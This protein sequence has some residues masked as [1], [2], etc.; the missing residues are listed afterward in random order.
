MSQDHAAPPPQAAIMG[1]VSSIW[2]AQAV[3]SFAKLGIADLLA[4]GPKNA[5]ELAAASGTNPD[6]LYRLL[7]GVASVN[8]LA[9]NPDGRFSLTPVG[10]CLRKDVPGSMRSM[11]IAELAPGHWLPWGHLD[12]AVRTGQPSAPAVLGMTIWD[13]YKKNAEEGA[14]FA[15]AMSGLSAMAMQ[16][17]MAAYSFAGARK[18]VDVGG[19]LGVFLTAVLQQEPA[20]RGV[21][22][23]LPQVVEG[24]QAALQA[25]GVAERVERIGGSF[26]ESVPK[27]GDV[28][29]IK[30]ILHDWSDDECVK[31][32]QNVREAMLPD[33]RVVV[34]EMP[35]ESGGPPSP[36]PLLDLNMLVMLTGKERT[37]AEYGE[38][39]ARAGLK[40]AGITRTPSPFAV[41]EARKA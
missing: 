32:L 24:A 16:A 40:L 13:H 6:A 25:A 35:I 15:A 18:V 33:G 37:T 41:L 23:D 9:A 1:F 8:V 5:T 22:Y 38:L 14:H 17:V 34:V 31:I 39:F 30:H 12:D 11:I 36:A 2:A 20:A 29:L 26:F 3:A 27:G 10:E 7:R 19:S 21:L 28:Y 4:K